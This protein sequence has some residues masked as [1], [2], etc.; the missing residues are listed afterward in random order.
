MKK[1]YLSLALTLALLCGVFAFP[2]VA[3]A[4][5]KVTL[6]FATSSLTPTSVIGELLKEFEAENPNVTIL[7]E[8]APGNDLIFKI[9]TD[10]M[11]NNC[12]D[13]FTYWRPEKKWDF[14][15]YVSIGAVAD[16]SELKASP[17]YEGMFPDYAWNTG[18]I[19]GVVYGIPRTNFYTCFIVNKE[20][21]EKLNLELPTDWDK[22]VKA[23][24][25]L[26]KAGYVVWA[27]DT[28]ENLDDAS[29][30]FNAVI[31]ATLGN[32]RGLS[33]MTG[34]ESWKQPDVIE[35]LGY[36]MEVA[37]P[38]YAPEDSSVLTSTSVI[39]KYLNTDRAGMLIQNAGQVWNNIPFE[40][41]D[42]FVALNF[43][44]TPTTQVDGP[45]NELDLTN[46][47]YASAKGYADP[48]KK[49]YIVKLINKLTSNE[50]AKRYAE[51]DKAIIPH[52]NVTPDPASVHPLQTEAA[53]LAYAATSCKWM[54]SK[55][56]SEVV[57]EFRLAINGVYYGEFESPEALAERLD[58]AL[59]G[60]Q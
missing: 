28:G 44:L 55:T 3:A 21:F 34:Q 17:F 42:K 14:D 15:T 18:S 41:M 1:R 53:A 19:D 51:N 9:N 2:M 32:P 25:E 31:E 27:T 16:L 12:P 40:V 11:A 35:A 36:F 4:T 37:K 49:E 5:D 56:S 33:L 60:K 57:D 45:F 30:L 43:P 59:Y 58:E 23:C 38:G 54:L 47:V 26:H 52:L 29:R 50:S 24:E 13:V 48:A 8:E 6:R 22:L 46:L 7:L 20:I 10:I 39:E